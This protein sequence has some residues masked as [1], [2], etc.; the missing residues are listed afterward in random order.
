[1]LKQ[2][3]HKRRKA[4]SSLTEVRLAAQLPRKMPAGLNSV[5]LAGLR[6]VALR[7]GLSML[8]HNRML[9]QHTVHPSLHSPKT[10]AR[11]VVCMAREPQH[12]N[13]L[14]LKGPMIGCIV[15]KLCS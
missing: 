3:V 1:M 12:P 14:K 9:Q 11:L 10:M 2:A 7:E 15:P 8:V 6:S 4:A 5:C 13:V